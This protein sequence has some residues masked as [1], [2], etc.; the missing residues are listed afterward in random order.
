MTFLYIVLMSFESIDV[1]NK[2]Q[3]EV[4]YNVLK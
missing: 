3:K 2:L 1:L 4:K